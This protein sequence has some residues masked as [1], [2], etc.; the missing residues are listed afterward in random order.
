[1]A[2]VSIL[3]MYNNYTDIFDDMALPDGVD[4]DLLINSIITELAEMAD[5][6]TD[7]LRER[8]KRG[9]DIQKAVETPVR[10]KNVGY[11]PY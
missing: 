3:T 11:K 8:I 2:W 1:M 10:G 7:T 4:R 6:R 9:M 5:I